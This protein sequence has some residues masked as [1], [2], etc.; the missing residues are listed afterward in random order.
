MRIYQIKFDVN[1]FQTFLPDNQPGIW[2]TDALLFDCHPKRQKWVAPPVYVPHPIRPAPDF[3][4]LGPGAII[5]SPSAF[6]KINRLFVRC[7][8]I[9][10]LPF[11]GQEFKILNITACVNCVDQ[12]HSEWL[13]AEGKRVTPTRYAFRGERVES[14][15]IFKVPESRLADMFCP[16]WSVD[17]QEEFKAAVEE[18]GLTGLRFKLVWES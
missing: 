8:E 4:R 15:P 1:Q 6:E 7:G 11:D 16:E 5:A 14:Y 3:W 18:L 10:P 13:I 2:G 12:E 17:P 9:L